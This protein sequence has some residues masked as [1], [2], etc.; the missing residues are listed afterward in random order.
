MR[1]EEF[2]IYKFLEK[3]NIRT[4]SI[5]IQQCL[6]VIENFQA[7]LVAGEDNGREEKTQNFVIERGRN[8][9]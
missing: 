5:I 6:L 1:R 9:T 8:K 3:F 7:R 4:K 2:S